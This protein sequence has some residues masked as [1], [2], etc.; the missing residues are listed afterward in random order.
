[1]LNAISREIGEPRLSHLKGISAKGWLQVFK[2]IKGRIERD[3]IPIVTSGIAFWFMLAVF[4]LIAAM[5]SIAGLAIDPQAMADQ[6]GY[7]AAS[8]P[9]ETASLLRGQAQAIASGGESVGW[10]ALASLVLTLYS[11][12][13]GTKNLMDGLNIACQVEETRGV[14][15]RNAVGVALTLVLIGIAMLGLAVVAVV[16]LLLQ[17]IGLA[18]TFGFLI[19]F[20]R[21]PILAL[22]TILSFAVIYR[23]GPHRRNAHWRWITPGALF[24]TLLWLVGSALFS[25]FIQNFGNYNETYGSLAG[26]IILMLWLWLSTFCVLFGAE[27]NSELERRTPDGAAQQS[28]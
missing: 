25:V 23:F 18:S 12:S 13:S 21:W 8:L 10:I 4:P 5:V 17:A 9:Q 3:N 1:M 24:G 7:F 6:M 27:L 11:A 22:L 26:V 14:L 19:A 28:G 15:K 2:N 20:V 16:P